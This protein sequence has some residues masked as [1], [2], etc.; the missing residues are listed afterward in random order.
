MYKFFPGRE[1]LFPV[2]TFIG[3]YFN[4]KTS[5]LAALKRSYSISRKVPILAIFGYLGPP[6][7]SIF[8]M[9]RK[10]IEKSSVRFLGVGIRNIVLNFELTISSGLRRGWGGPAVLQIGIFENP[11]F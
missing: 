1:W 2:S 9:Y 7:K 5:S 3:E 11:C 10:N 6:S 8:S 4:E